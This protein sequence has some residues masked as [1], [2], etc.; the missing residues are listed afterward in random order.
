MLDADR[1]STNIN[2]CTECCRIVLVSNRATST[3]TSIE[4]WESSCDCSPRAA[5]G[6]CR[7]CG[8]HR[9]VD[10]A[11]R[12]WT[13]SLKRVVCLYRNVLQIQQGLSP[14]PRGALETNAPPPHE[15]VSLLS[16]IIFT[17]FSIIIEN[18]RQARKSL[19]PFYARHSRCDRAEDCYEHCHTHL[20]WKHPLHLL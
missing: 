14:C 5:K 2:Q 1:A 3:S 10:E 17:F 7:A 12:K 18:I 19:R 11:N 16:N 8:V 6:R 15:R 13:D 9:T 4:I 20:L